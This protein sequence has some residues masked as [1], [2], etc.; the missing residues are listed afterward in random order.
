MSNSFDNIKRNSNKFSFISTFFDLVGNKEFKQAELCTLYTNTHTKET[1]IWRSISAIAQEM[2]E[3]FYSNVLNFINGVAN[4][5]T[6]KI[7]QL[8]SLISSL[9]IEH[10]VFSEIKFMPVD[11]VKLI[12]LLSIKKEYLTCYSIM[13]SDF[14]NDL[15]KN[16]TINLETN[17]TSANLSSTLCSINE[18]NYDRGYEQLAYDNLSIYWED[19]PILSS[20]NIDDEKLN[21]FISS[22]FYNLL[23]SKITQTYN[24]KLGDQIYKVLSDTILYKDFELENKYSDT[25]NSYKKLFNI[26]TSFD[27][28][29]E[30][31]NYE[32]GLVDLSD[33]STQE[34]SLLTIEINRRKEPYIQAEPKTRYKFYKERE[35]K[36]YTEFIQNENS[37]KV[38][39]TNYISSSTYAIDNNYSEINNQNT[40]KLFKTTNDNNITFRNELL[41]LVA[42]Q[43][44]SIT[45]SIREIREQTKTQCQK[46]YM[47]GTKQFL[48]YFIKE[49]LRNNIVKQ[50]KENNLLN[51]DYNILSTGALD[52]DITEYLDYT[53]YFNI[54]SKTDNDLCALGI[55]PKN[56]YALLNPKYWE[57][58][59][60]LYAL[61]GNDSTNIFSDFNKV[62]SQDFTINNEVLSTLY[63]N[64]LKN[65]FYTKNDRSNIQYKLLTDFLKTV[66]QIG[67]ENTFTVD[68]VSVHTYDSNL[69]SETYK[70]CNEFWSERICTIL[71]AYNGLYKNIAKSDEIIQSFSDTSSLEDQLYKIYINYQTNTDKVLTYINPLSIALGELNELTTK[72]SFDTMAYE[73][74]NKYNNL[75][76]GLL[77][78]LEKSI[79]TDTFNRY[80]EMED[81]YDTTHRNYNLISTSFALVSDYIPDDFEYSNRTLKDQIE[82][83]YSTIT[84]YT[85]EQLSDTNIQNENEQ[86]TISSNIS[87]L[88]VNI[89]N[90]NAMLSSIELNTLLELLSND[91]EQTLTKMSTEIDIIRKSDLFKYRETLFKQYSGK[92]IGNTPWYYI[93][94]Y[95]HPSFM[96]HPYL[97]NY[98][99][100]NDYNFPIENQANIEHTTQQELIKDCLSDIMDKDGY[101]INMWKNPLNSN[102]DYLSRYEQA[103]HT[104]TDGKDHPEIAYD[105]F[106]YPPAVAKLSANLNEF[107]N[108]LNTNDN[109]YYKHLNL[110]KETREHIIKQLRLCK[111]EI[112]DIA[113]NSKY[114]IFRYGL[115]IYGNTYILVKQ[116][117]TDDISAIDYDIRLK[118]PGTLWMRIKNHPI[119]FPAYLISCNQTGSLNSENIHN[120]GQIQCNDSSNIEFLEFKDN[121]FLKYNEVNSIRYPCI[122]D[123]TF[124]DDKNILVINGQYINDADR[125]NNTIGALPIIV[126]VNQEYNQKTN[127]TEY[128]HEKLKTSI[129]TLID[130]SDYKVNELSDFK[131]IYGITTIDEDIDPIFK[132]Y[133][134]RLSD[135]TFQT[136]WNYNNK[137]G[138]IYSYIKTTKTTEQNKNKYLSTF[139]IFVLGGYVNILDGTRERIYIKHVDCISS[140]E[141]LENVCVDANED[142]IT[143]AYLDN[144]HISADIELS[145]YI[146][147]NLKLSYLQSYASF[148]QPFIV[149]TKRYVLGVNELA[150][151]KTVPDV[152]Y[153]HSYMQYTDIGFY[154]LIGGN[155]I[156]LSSKNELNDTYISEC[157]YGKDNNNIARRKFY[158]FQIIAPEITGNSNST[159]Y[160]F[161]KSFVNINDLHLRSFENSQ[162]LCTITLAN[163]ESINAI[164]LLDLHHYET[165]NSEGTANLLDYSSLST[166]NSV[167]YTVGE[168]NYITHQNRTGIKSDEIDKVVNDIQSLNVGNNAV[169]ANAKDGTHDF[170]HWNSNPDNCQFTI[171]DVN[172]VPQSISVSWWKNNNGKINLNFNSYY[173]T[174]STSSK[175][176]KNFNNVANCYCNLTANECGIL[177]LYKGLTI[178]SKTSDYT[179]TNNTQDKIL[180]SYRICNISDDKPKFALSV[181]KSLDA[182]QYAFIGED[183]NDNIAFITQNS[184]DNLSNVFRYEQQFYNK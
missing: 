143:V 52:I 54:S 115:D 156:E 179:D 172:N 182:T 82:T 25:I 124:S 80:Q 175:F 73:L 88:S 96:V 36:E 28:E 114:D 134:N 38:L 2:G 64:V 11:V 61:G 125:Y 154:G 141:H 113:M 43:L 166:N 1:S 106:C 118:T 147:R 84:S 139:D 60:S 85:K 56:E 91:Y 101:L 27:V 163:R 89:V 181:I 20:T 160:P 81:F 177:T 137:I 122:Y 132:T 74:S 173:H 103:S 148:E 68:D 119:A 6:C 41:E 157:E 17:D 4:I 144:I 129:L 176:A 117:D 145:N 8:Q 167:V 42:N 87:A 142:K 63:L 5:D 133:D 9:G 86:K 50:L 155:T 123:F 152:S 58:H 128:Y 174:A 53:N 112:V 150:E 29:E 100:K 130:E 69:I 14:A 99:E 71:T 22:A 169:I 76:N 19:T 183:K 45:I 83:F 136:F 131:S 164:N 48:I 149:K 12:D 79:E 90:A 67:A 184:N 135:Y 120:L 49:Y 70:S 24:N 161:S 34:L 97:C 35:V 158:K 59:A 18:L 47:R 127:L 102:Q 26:Q 77:A 23:K 159:K 7:A 93:E 94:N 105:G 51:S 153:E 40:V 140:Y 55:I 126:K 30:V 62:W 116:Y 37:N 121:D 13:D 165:L 65:R 21:N 104:G 44:K 15:L 180:A 107:I 32:N 98:I 57:T 33:Y 31:D 92:K 3:E 108:G 138:A 75:D 95:T 151:D 39:S 72:M 111:D 171:E 16:Y 10:S 170:K 162:P 46:I 110:S 109:E 146:N 178:S 168:Y 78:V 66:Y